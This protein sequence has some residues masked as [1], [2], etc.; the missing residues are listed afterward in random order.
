MNDTFFIF[1]VVL[2]QQER[3]GILVSLAMAPS[4]GATEKLGYFS[5]RPSFGSEQARRFLPEGLIGTGNFLFCLG[6][7]DKDFIFRRRGFGS[8]I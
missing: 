7:P 1:G 5:G 4:R 8:R 2:A 3:V 6:N